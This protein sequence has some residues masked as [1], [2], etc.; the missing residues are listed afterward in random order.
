[1][2]LSVEPPQ[3]PRNRSIYNRRWSSV[4]PSSQLTSMKEQQ[5]LEAG[6]VAT[7]R[8]EASTSEVDDC[9]GYSLVLEESTLDRSCSV[10]V[11]SAPQISCHLIQTLVKPVLQWLFGGQMNRGS[12]RGFARERSYWTR[13]ALIP[14]HSGIFNVVRRGCA[15]CYCLSMLRQTPVHEGTKAELPDTWSSPRPVPWFGN[16]LRSSLLDRQ[17][18]FS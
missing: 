8:T 10:L 6:S 4:D 16:S 17:L 3:A 1:M 12:C 13:I 7:E 18:L 11:F 2:A 5:C 14:V 15:A 9:I